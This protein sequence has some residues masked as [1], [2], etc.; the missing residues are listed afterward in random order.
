MIN[1][2]LSYRWRYDQ[3]L[4]MENDYPYTTP[5]PNE[6]EE[7]KQASATTQKHG[8]EVEL[9][10]K[11]LALLGVVVLL[12]FIVWGG[13]QLT[14]ITPATF[15]AAVSNFTSIFVGREEMPIIIETEEREVESGTPFTLSFSHGNAEVGT[16][17]FE[18]GCNESVT[19]E[20]GGGEIPCG[21]ATA[22]DMDNE[23]R[24]VVFTPYSTASESTTLGASVTFIPSGSDTASVSAAIELTLLPRTADEV[25]GGGTSPGT[26][27]AGPRREEVRVITGG[28]TSNP[29]FSDPNGIPDLAVTILATGI[30]DKSTGVFTPLVPV[31]LDDRA[32]LR[33][34]IRNVGTK[35]TGPWSFIVDLPLS[36]AMYVFRPEETQQSLNPGERIEYTLGFDRITRNTGIADIAVHVDTAREVP[37]TNRNNNTA[38]STISIETN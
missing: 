1:L 6:A 23:N 38:L 5:S 3:Q 31:G 18:Y 19:V 15:T 36:G 33:F 28:G 7:A 20:M 24:R 26:V 37:E 14:G 12:G 25:S 13:I 9:G 22:I 21:T 10:K 35:A 34:E 17:L 8:T 27:T 30:V 2:F 29:T 4:I 11:T 16:Y 32:G